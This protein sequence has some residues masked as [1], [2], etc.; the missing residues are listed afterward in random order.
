LRRGPD[1]Q[2]TAGQGVNLEVQFHKLIVRGNSSGRQFECPDLF[3]IQSN[4]LEVTPCLLKEVCF[5][6]ERLNQPQAVSPHQHTSAPSPY[7][8]EKHHT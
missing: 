8:K 6:L 7:F 2:S 3:A 4:K 1:Y 5:V